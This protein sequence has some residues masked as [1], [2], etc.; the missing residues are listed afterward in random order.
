MKFV[1]SLT[2]RPNGS[3]A[4]NE[5]AVRRMLDVYS[6]WTPPAGMAIHQ[7]MSRADGGGSFAIVETDSASDLIDATSTFTPFGDYEIYPVVDVADG[8]RA[9]QEAIAFR[10]SIN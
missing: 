3:A 6:K 9:S 8:V 5:V 4:D 2:F 1:V 7:I 10:E